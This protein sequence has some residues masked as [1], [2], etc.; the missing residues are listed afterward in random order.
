MNRCLFFLLLSFLIISSSLS[1]EIVDES[2]L[3]L[4]SQFTFNLLSPINPLTP[5]WK[6]GYVQEINT[7]W[8]VGMEYGYGNY[9]LAFLN[10][11]F[12]PEFSFERY[13]QL[14]ELRTSVFYH[15]IDLKQIDCYF[16]VDLYYINHKDVLYN[17]DYLST[18][19]NAYFL[20]DQVDFYR[21][22]YGLLPL[23]NIVLWENKRVGL[24]AYGGA[25][26]KIRSQQFSNVVNPTLYTGRSPDVMQFVR[27]TGYQIIEGPELAVDVN[28]GLKLVMKIK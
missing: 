26:L 6:I 23:L 8:K 28:L 22:K 10:Y 13:Y 16:S 21:Q 12:D 4:T 2:K 17:G 20:Y 19:E 27:P 5:K 1:Q 7:K 11:Q 3:P 9:H 15:V 18:S 14:W 25:G 24:L